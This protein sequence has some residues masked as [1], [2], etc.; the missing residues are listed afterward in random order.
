MH[1]P[2]IL[3]LTLLATSSAN[4]DAYKCRLADGSLEISSRPC[5]AG[6][7][8][9]GIKAEER[10]PEQR[11]LEAWR[12]VERLKAQLETQNAAQNQAATPQRPPSP[13]ADN[14]RTSDSPRRTTEE[15]LQALNQRPLEPSHRT[16]LENLCHTNPDAEPVLIPVPTPVP[17]PVTTWGAPPANPLG[18]CIASTQQLNLP[19]QEKL[20][21]FRE[22]EALYG[23]PQSTPR[24][25]PGK[26]PAAPTHSAGE[27]RTIPC[28]PGNK[29][30]R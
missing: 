25:V 28:L 18:E 19:A 12:E 2:V 4:A 23:I 9:L 17:T 30:C 1:R 11:R 22:C 26:P 13:P 16:Q 21:R 3:L 6:S 29:D 24:G 7:A 20:Q 27:I 10:I 5:A 8:T 15:C 14:P